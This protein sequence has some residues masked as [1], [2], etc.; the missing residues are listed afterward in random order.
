L[1][2]NYP[3][4]SDP[5]KQVARAYGVVGL[6]RPLPRR[7]TFFIGPDGR[8]LAID[9]KVKP[10]SHGADVAARLEKLDVAQKKKK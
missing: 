10:G 7:W 4:L 5:D 9:K 3:I 8:I 6:T 1:D 2:L